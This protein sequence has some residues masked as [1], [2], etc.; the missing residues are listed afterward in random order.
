M[1][2]PDR[3]SLPLDGLEAVV[4]DTDGVLTDTARVH[5]AA[6]KRL[7]DEYRAQRAARMGEFYRPFEDADYL[8]YI[9]GRPRYDG[10]AD[11][12]ASRG[13]ALPGATRPTRGP[14][15]GVRPGQRR[16][17]VPHHPPPRTRR[18][19][20]PDLGR[21]RAPAAERRCADRGRVGQPHMIAVLEAA[22]LRDLFDAEVDRAEADRLGLAGKPDPAL[23]LEAV[24][25]LQMAPTRAAVVEDALAGWRRAAAAGSAWSWA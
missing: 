17:R 7:F 24:R 9:D 19:R 16:G 8:H 22:G 4:L 10:V 5:A 15:N 20:L 18:R 1:T 23:F 13:I 6:W 25:R 3:P 12:L 21:V 14:G 2:E 11:F